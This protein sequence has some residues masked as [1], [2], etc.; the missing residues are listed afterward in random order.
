MPYTDSIIQAVSEFETV[1]A[2]R[3]LAF[4]ASGVMRVNQCCDLYAVGVFLVVAPL[5]A[6]ALCTVTLN[7]APGNAVGAVAVAN[8]TVPFATA[9]LGQIYWQEPEVVA[10]APGSLKSMK[11]KAGQ[12]LVFTISG[13]NMTT[14]VWRPWVE[15]YPRPEV[16]ANIAAFVQSTT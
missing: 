7:V 8:V 15:A 5:I 16:K 10:G 13:Q 9:V 1:G 12:E 6:N 3:D 14:M 11:L 4:N 2:T